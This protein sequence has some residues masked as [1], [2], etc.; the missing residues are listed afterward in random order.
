MYYPVTR[1]RR[2]R[3]EHLLREMVKETDINVRSFIYPVFVTEGTDVKDPVTSM[4]GI[5]RFS[6]DN[7]LKE[8]KEIDGLRIPAVMLF[9]VPERKDER[10]SAAFAKNGL[11]QTAIKA[12]KDKY[13]H[14]L[15]ITDVCLCA[16]TP[17][18]HC[19]I[20]KNKVGVKEEQL[21]ESS[22][23]Q[24]VSQDMVVYNDATC[25]ILA[26]MALSHAEAGADMVA[27][28]S[29]MDGQV[30][31]IRK[32][33]DAN[34]FKHIPIMA[35]SVKYAS[36]FYMPF[37]DAAQSAPDQGDR[38]AYQM[39]PANVVEAMREIEL[40]IQEG[41]DI[42]MVKPA[43]AYLDVIAKAKQGYSVPLAAYNVSGEFAMIKAAAAQGL[44]DE[45]SAVLEILTSIKRAGA[46]I[47]ITY[48][49]KDAARW[50]S[51]QFLL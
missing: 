43:L 32:V 44:I 24:A 13:P 2:L 30:T 26:K 33:L 23:E 45:K 48:H 35:Y 51:G 4:P 12:L 11:V 38:K 46:D 6:V 19:G 14:L 10:A 34:N 22:A 29:M 20:I 9:G 40:D 36:S 49:A 27:P 28:S 8:A 47:I 50:L 15:V 17:S 1:L 42:V 5:C 31:A 39:N 3:K 25:E 41:A 16:Y 21:Q 18:G 37:R 7:L